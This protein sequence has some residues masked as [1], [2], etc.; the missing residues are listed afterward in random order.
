MTSSSN[1]QLR[2]KSTFTRQTA[3]RTLRDNLDTQGDNTFVVL[4]DRKH[5]ELDRIEV[6][7]SRTLGTNSVFG[8][9][10]HNM[11]S[12]KF[13]SFAKDVDKTLASDA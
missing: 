8:I 6:S 3:N 9:Q 2:N 11:D 7:T 10:K 1:F 5:S 4:K 12:S 13:T